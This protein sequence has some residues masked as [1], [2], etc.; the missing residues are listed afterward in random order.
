MP[1]FA[2]AFKAS[3]LDFLNEK[4]RFWVSR[5]DEISRS[6]ISEHVEKERKV[7]Y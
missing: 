7:Y 6:E 4:A 1:R 3:I 5:R 2:M